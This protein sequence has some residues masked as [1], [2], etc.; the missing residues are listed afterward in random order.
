MSVGLLEG[1]LSLNYVHLRALACLESRWN[2]VKEAFASQWSHSLSSKAGTH[3]VEKDS[4][5]PKERM[6]NIGAIWAGLFSPFLW[7]VWYRK[8]SKNVFNKF[9]LFG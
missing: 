1:S 7:G 4:L 5:V 6:W 9:R 3:R 2:P 8:E